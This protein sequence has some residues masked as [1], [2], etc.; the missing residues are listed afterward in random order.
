MPA[1]INLQGREVRTLVN[2][3][4]QT[5]IQTRLTDQEAVEICR[6]Q[7]QGKD[8]SFAQSLVN[9]SAKYSLSPGQLFWLHKLAMDVVESWRNR[10]PDEGVRV[11]DFGRLTRMF[12]Y[13]LHW[14]ASQPDQSRRAMRLRIF[15]SF[16]VPVG[17]VEFSIASDRSRYKGQLMLSNGSYENNKYY[18]RVDQEGKY[19]PGKDHFGEILEFLER[20]AN[21]PE[22]FA[23]EYG[24]KTGKCCLCGRPLGD[25]KGDRDAQTG[26]ITQ[27]GSSVEQGFGLVCARRF[28]F[29]HSHLTVAEK[30][31][32]LAREGHLP[33]E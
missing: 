9:N 24:Q 12:R 29:Y 19:H 22:R 21:N 13:A 31:E 14:L 3:K 26:E 5:K 25:E 30:Q 7:V 15:F 17:D 8:Q 16:P 11:G 4:Y 1:I 2:P 27:R 32:Y 28:G 6:N 23:R 10:H 33:V 20:F 18:G